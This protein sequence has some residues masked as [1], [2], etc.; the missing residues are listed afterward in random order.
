M[1][2]S[3]NNL[4]PSTSVERVVVHGDSHRQYGPIDVLQVLGMHVHFKANAENFYSKTS[5]EITKC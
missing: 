5:D 4:K 2:P 3:S 1:G